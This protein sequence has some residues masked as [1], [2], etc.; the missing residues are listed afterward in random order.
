MLKVCSLDLGS[1]RQ[2]AVKGVIDD[3]I[4][5]IKDYKYTY[6]EEKNIKEKIKKLN[7]FLEK[8][9]LSEEF[10]FVILE[11]KFKST[12]KT[13]IKVSHSEYKAFVMLNEHAKNKLL[14]EGIN[15]LTVVSSNIEAFFVK[16]KRSNYFVPG[17][18]QVLTGVNKPSDKDIEEA[19]KILLKEGKIVYEVSTSELTKNETRFY[20]DFN[21]AV[22]MLYAYILRPEIFVFEEV[23]EKKDNKTELYNEITKELLEK[24]LGPIVSWVK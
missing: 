22:G 15:L 6:I 23:E 13:K 8:N 7:E 14:S 4:L 1:R 17:W 9:V 20:A 3:A 11:K 10:D 2:V 16:S 24:F 21:D 12:K 5:R 18:K 19:L